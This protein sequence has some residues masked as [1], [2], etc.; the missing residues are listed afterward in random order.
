[1]SKSRGWCFTINN[2]TE[3][4][5]VDCE[6]LEDSG[7]IYYVYG[8]EKGE[9]GTPHLQGFVRYKNP[10]SFN[11]IRQLLPRAHVEAQKGSCVDASTY[12]KKD[13]DYKEW[14]DIPTGKRTS[15]E[16]WRFLIDA[17]ERG[18][19]ESVKREYPGDYFRYFDRLVRLRVRDTTILD[20]IQHEWWYGPT[21]TGKSKKVWEDY[22]DHYA[23]MLNKWWDG[24]A[25]EDVVVIEEWAPRNECTA[26]A[27]KIW[28]DR[29]PFPVEVKGGNLRRIRPRKIIV[30]SNYTIDQCFEK[31]EDRDP[32]KRRFKQVYFPRTPFMD[33]SFLDEETKEN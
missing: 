6:K 27:L 22:P 11:R 26:S 33:L 8:K 32:I 25:N 3:W 12:C 2:P 23:K 18:D 9:C 10:I 19:L 14:G 20:E 21:G 1:M 4:D 24:Y 5:E 30:T 7:A 31:A 28:A 13:G 29:Y 16:R 15:D 17:G